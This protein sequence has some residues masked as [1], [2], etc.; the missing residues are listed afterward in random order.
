MT[1]PI[2]RSRSGR[3]LR[4]V[5]AALMAMAVGSVIWGAIPILEWMETWR[6]A[7]MQAGYL[8]VIVFIVLYTVAVVIFAP[9]TPFT[10]AAG[11][12]YGYWGVPISLAGA[13]SGAVLSFLIARGSLRQRWSVLCQQQRLSHSLDAAV[14][15]LGW[16]AVLLVRLS[17]L[18]PFSLQN[19]LF[20]MTGVSIGAFV[21]AGL[22]G[23]IPATIVKAFLGIFG[24]GQAHEQSPYVV[25][26]V[27][28]GM[29]ATLWVAWVFARHM[30][31]TH[32]ELRLGQNH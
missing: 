12:F 28:V 15:A 11:A 10:I 4:V 9:A 23:M 20:G 1:D 19:Y 14:A 6:G 24:S 21:I 31:L 13:L 26:L 22:L 30:R 7:V 3:P 32:G 8:G 5:L 27:G 18:V 17:P 2:N 25:G 29:L 16:K